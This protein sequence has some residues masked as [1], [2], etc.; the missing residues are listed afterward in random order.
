M[1]GMPAMLARMFVE[2]NVTMITNLNLWT[3]ET[4][5]LVT[6]KFNL[7]T[8]AIESLKSDVTRENKELETKLIFKSPYLLLPLD[9]LIFLP[10]GLIVLKGILSKTIVNHLCKSICFFLKFLQKQHGR[11]QPWKH[12]IPTVF[13]LK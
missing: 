2:N 5:N 9:L 3:I 11:R 4:Q 13:L 10:S 1:I 6:E 12:D 8:T 7:A